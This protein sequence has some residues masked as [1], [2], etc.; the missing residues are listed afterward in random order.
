[1]KICC[2]VLFFYS[3]SAQSTKGRKRHD[4][5]KKE[6]VPIFARLCA[7]EGDWWVVSL[8]LPLQWPKKWLPSD[9]NNDAWYLGFYKIFNLSM[10]RFYQE[11][12]QQIIS[13]FRSHDSPLHSNPRYRTNSKK[14]DNFV[15]LVSLL[16]KCKWNNFFIKLNFVDF[17]KRFPWVNLN[18]KISCK[19]I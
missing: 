13:K 7:W 9:S 4:S 1:M 10:V 19:I 3:L 2:F 17:I 11:Y 8:T 16:K 15:D 14:Q 5:M 18:I 6:G 12:G